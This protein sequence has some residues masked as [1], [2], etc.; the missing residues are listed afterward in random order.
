MNDKEH[1]YYRVNDME[2]DRRPLCTMEQMVCQI[3]HKFPWDDPDRVSKACDL[4]EEIM[5]EC[6]RRRMAVAGEMMS[7]Q[8]AIAMIRQ[9]QAIKAVELTTEQTNGFKEFVSGM[10][11]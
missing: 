6:L 10:K 8:S 11:A 9:Y 5:A 2:V 1:L 3:I 7:L 4:V